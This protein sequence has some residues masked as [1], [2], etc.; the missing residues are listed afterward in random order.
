MRQRRRGS[1]LWLRSAATTLLGVAAFGCAS[2]P[3][4]GKAIWAYARRQGGRLVLRLRQEMA[5][6]VTTQP[7]RRLEATP[8]HLWH[9]AECSFGWAVPCGGCQSKWLWG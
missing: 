6:K 4:V 3:D 2:P 8:R 9:R 5:L 7:L 1:R